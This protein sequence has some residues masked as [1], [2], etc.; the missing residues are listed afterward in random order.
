[1]I[2]DKCISV[3]NTYFFT[4]VVRYFT[5]CTVYSLSFPLNFSQ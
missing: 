5:L 4:G 2:N 3:P 1:M